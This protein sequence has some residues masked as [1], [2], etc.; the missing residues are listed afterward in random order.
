M[1]WYI[2]DVFGEEV[3]PET[4]LPD[5]LYQFNDQKIKPSAELKDEQV[6]PIK[7]GYHCGLIDRIL[8]YRKTSMAEIVGWWSAGTL[9][10]EIGVPVAMMEAYGVTK[11]ETFLTDLKWFFGQMYG[12]TFKRVQSV[13]IIVTSKTAFGFDYR[14]SILPFEAMFQGLMKDDAVETKA[15]D[16][17]TYKPKE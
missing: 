6:D 7:V 13:P 9:H 2:N 4:L 17:A 16:I 1:A 10:K 8:D 12:Q 11:A 5:D 14:E 15:L 3:I